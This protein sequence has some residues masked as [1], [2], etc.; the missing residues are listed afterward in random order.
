MSRVR[1]EAGTPDLQA[2]QA[3]FCFRGGGKVFASS[4]IWL[5]ADWEGIARAGGDG[6]GMVNR[7]RGREK[8]TEVLEPW[9]G[10]VWD[11]IGRQADARQRE[12]IASRGKGVPGSQGVRP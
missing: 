9:G 1:D 6:P 12:R 3:V 5:W 4:C 2:S 11:N 10:K 7:K 8:E